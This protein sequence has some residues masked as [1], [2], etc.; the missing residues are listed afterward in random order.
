MLPAEHSF[1][2]SQAGKGSCSGEFREKTL[3]VLFKISSEE[4]G[5]GWSKRFLP[6]WQPC[7]GRTCHPW[8]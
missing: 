3:G 6:S 7:V 2:E 4:N 1:N 8:G 5:S